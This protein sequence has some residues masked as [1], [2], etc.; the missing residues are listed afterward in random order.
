MVDNLKE[1]QL[2]NE[3]F[4]MDDNCANKK[5]NDDVLSMVEN[6]TNDEK[7]KEALKIER[8]IKTITN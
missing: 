1:A 7:E 5:S 2:I 4:T 6:M 8:K 3:F